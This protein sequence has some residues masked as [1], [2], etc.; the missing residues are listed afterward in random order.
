MA[1]KHNYSLVYAG[2]HAIDGH[3]DAF[4]IRNK[5]LGSLTTPNIKDFKHVLY[6]AY[7]YCITGRSKIMMDYETWLETKDEKTSKHKALKLSKLYL[8]SNF[9][10]NCKTTIYHL[11]KKIKAKHFVLEIEL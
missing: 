3:H 1:E 2:K 10:Q 8:E 7:S 5:L 11:M 4:F 9:I 6:P